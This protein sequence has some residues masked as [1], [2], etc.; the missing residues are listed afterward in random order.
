MGSCDTFTCGSTF[1][2]S[3]RT[4]LSCAPLGRST[5]SLRLASRWEWVSQLVR[6]GPCAEAPCVTSLSLWPCDFSLCIEQTVQDCASCGGDDLQ[7]GQVTLIKVRGIGSEHQHALRCGGVDT[8]IPPSHTLGVAAEQNGACPRWG[9]DV[10][11]GIDGPGGVLDV[12]NGHIACPGR[13]AVNSHGILT[14]L[15]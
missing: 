12:A 15:L 5:S 14:S 9:V 10:L 6:R 4:S 1:W 11:S 13:S 7:L 3:P 2:R 8:I